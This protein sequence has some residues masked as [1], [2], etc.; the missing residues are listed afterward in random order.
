MPDPTD[1]TDTNVPTNVDPARRTRPTITIDV[2]DRPI[3]IQLG[4]RP[5]FLFVGTLSAPQLANT[6]A[7]L[8]AQA[9][10][11]NQSDPNAVVQIHDQVMAALADLLHDQDDRGRWLQ[12]QLP[13]TALV[14]T[15]RPSVLGALMEEW[16][17]RPLGSA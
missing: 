16:T 7:P 13:V 6:L 15:D 14:A 4:D 3:P 11:L 8:Q 1:P 17:G 2:D 10:Q 12:L 9:A 5:P